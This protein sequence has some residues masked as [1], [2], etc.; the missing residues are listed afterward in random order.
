MRHSD[1]VKLIVLYPH[2]QEMIWRALTQH[3]KMILWYFEQLEEFKAEL[4][5]QTQFVVQ[6]EGRTFTHIWEVTEIKP[7]KTI[8]Y[9][10]RFKEYA[11]QGLVR[12]ELNAKD[13]LTELTL[14]NEGLHTYPNDIPEFT[15]ESCLGGWKYFLE[16]N[17]KAYLDK[18][19]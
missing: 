4:G 6:N 1:P 8:A 7:G 18:I 13:G 12:F 14:T 10:W 16:Q 3:S 5:F 11:G 19:S 9:S 2:P 17:L 15:R